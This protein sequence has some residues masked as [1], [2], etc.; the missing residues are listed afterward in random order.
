MDLTFP[1]SNSQRQT[2]AS[3]T[4]C[5]TSKASVNLFATQTVKLRLSHR[6]LKTNSSLT[7]L[8]MG[9]QVR[10]RVERIRGPISPKYKRSLMIP[11]RRQ[12]KLCR[13]SPGRGELNALNGTVSTISI[14]SHQTRHVTNTRQIRT[15][16][17]SRL[18]PTTFRQCLRCSSSLIKTVTRTQDDS[19]QLTLRASREP[20]TIMQT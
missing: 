5:L 17:S 10:C 9:N 20:T 13:I 1:L 11:P 12:V 19:S 2:A 16:G 15:R 18:A 3:C 7:S 4:Q 6:I 14:A 8:T